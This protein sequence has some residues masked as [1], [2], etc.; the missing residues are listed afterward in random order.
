MYS[1]R[2]SFCVVPPIRSEEDRCCRVDGHRGRDLG[3]GDAV[4]ESREIVKRA[5]R[6]ADLPDLTSDRRIVRVVA[7]LCREIERHR[8]PGLAVLQEV[9]IPRVRLLRRPEPGVLPHRPQTAAVHRRL[10]PA[11][12]WRHAGHAWVVAVRIEDR[13]QRRAVGRLELGALAD[14]PRCPGVPRA[15]PFRTVAAV[16]WHPCDGTRRGSQRGL[17]ISVPSRRPS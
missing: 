11:G 13:G 6:D 9:A 7:H 12:E 3:E 4:E 10:D 2:M 5:D 17:K 8:Q 14:A 1:L 15:L 16:L